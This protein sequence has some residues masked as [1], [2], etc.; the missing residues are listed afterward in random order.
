MLQMEFQLQADKLLRDAKR[1]CL[2]CYGRARLRST[3]NERTIAFKAAETMYRLF[4]ER[5]NALR[6]SD[7]PTESLQ[8]ALEFKRLCLDAM[9][10]CK[11]CD[12]TVDYINRHISRIK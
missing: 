7:A 6:R 1:N 10:S 3:D 9:D 11:A 12:K 2:L 5:Y 4:E 8:K